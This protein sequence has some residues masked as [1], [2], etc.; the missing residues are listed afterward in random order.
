ME[1]AIRK[2]QEEGRGRGISSKIACDKRI[3]NWISAEKYERSNRGV[4]AEEAELNL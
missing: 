4:L 1:E 3:S 2:V